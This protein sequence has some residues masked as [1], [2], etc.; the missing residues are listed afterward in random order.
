[1]PDTVATIRVTL[2][3]GSFREVASGT[4]P[5]AVAESIGPRLAKDALVASIDGVLVDLDRPIVGDVAHQ[6]L[7]SKDRAALDVL[8][9]STAHATAQAVQE[10]FPGTKIGQGM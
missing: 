10:L 8:R 6:I 4:T 7:T 2:P 9:H 3:D 1:M 5:R